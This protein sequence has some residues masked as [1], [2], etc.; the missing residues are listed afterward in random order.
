MNDQEKL[1]DWRI[2]E[3]AETGAW[4]QIAQEYVNQFAE[5]KSEKESGYLDKAANKPSAPRIGYIVDY[6]DGVSS[7]QIQWEYPEI[8]KFSKAKVATFKEVIE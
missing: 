4:A 1:E 6:G 2:R 7:N 3:L 5:F 8:S